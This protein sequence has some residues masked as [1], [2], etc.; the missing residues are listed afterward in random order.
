MNWLS[1][2]SLEGAVEQIIPFEK[3][4]S[5]WKSREITE[6]QRNTGILVTSS[7]AKV[8]L[9]RSV[10][11]AAHKLNDRA[12]VWAGD[13]EPNVITR[14]IADDFILMPRLNDSSLSDITAA[15]IERHISTIIPTRDGE[16]EFWATH[17]SRLKESGIHVVVS[18]LNSVSRCLDK[19]E[20]A[21]FGLAKNLPFIPAS[22]SL[23]SLS[24]QDS[25]HPVYCV[26][27][28]FGAGSNSIGLNLTHAAALE[29][30]TL[31]DSP[32]FQPYIEGREISVDAWLDQQGQPKGI[33]MRYRDKVVNGESQITTTFRQT[34]WECTLF[35]ILSTLN[36]RGPVVLQAIIDSSD[37][38]HI[39]ECNSRFGGASTASIA[40]GLDSF[41]WSLLESQGRSLTDIPFVRIDGEVKQVR[42]PHDEL[43]HDFDI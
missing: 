29:H 43:I 32:V 38:L 22:K 28:R 42:V 9:I 20:F 13:C 2:V 6:Q 19:F 31:L 11:A 23:N 21:Q 25:E 33:I 7:S 10:L 37:N 39:I 12:T 3:I 5:H 34:D 36:L 30:A 18:P 41:Y 26:K 16:L 4:A 17:Q 1:E 14:Y 40:A 27:E 8:P 35:N 15:C 24:G